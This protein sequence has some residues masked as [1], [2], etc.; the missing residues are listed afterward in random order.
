MKGTEEPA[1]TPETSTSFDLTWIVVIV[2]AVVAGAF[3]ALRH[4]GDADRPPVPEGLP[5]DRAVPLL[6]ERHETIEAVRRVREALG[7]GLKDA[8]DLV[9]RVKA[10]EPAQAVF[11]HAVTTAARTGDG[12]DDE[13]RAL[14][15]K[16]EK[17]AAIKLVRERTGMG[18]AEAKGWVESR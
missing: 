11:P 16:G 6:L 2:I 7:I 3:V 8:K 9:D 10:G 12:L 5:L 14:M 13:V 15:A 17:I 1:V 4:R 18:L